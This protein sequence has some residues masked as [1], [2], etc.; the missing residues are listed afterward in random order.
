MSL[1]IGGILGILRATVLTWWVV[2]SDDPLMGASMAPSL[3]PGDLVI[4]WRGTVKFG[5]L[6]RC[7]DPES[8]GRYVV[9]RVMGEPNDQLEFKDFDLVVNDKRT[10]KEQTCSPSRVTIPDPSTGADVDLYCSI[11]AII[12]HKHLRAT[13]MNPQP[14]YTSGRRVTVAENQFYLVS[15]NRVYPLDSRDYGGVPKASCK[16]FVVL[17]IKGKKGW[18]DENSRL[19]FIQ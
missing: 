5:D 4:L 7:A 18:Q 6:A 1:V 2:P 19:T 9:G 16:E 8:P 15:D 11:E 14:Q 3:Y 12:G 10:T 17:R 13:P